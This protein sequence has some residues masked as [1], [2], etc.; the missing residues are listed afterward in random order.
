MK[1]KCSYKIGES[2]A[3]TNHTDVKVYFTK[4]LNRVLESTK[5]LLIKT[6][7][8]NHQ[9]MRPECSHFSHKMLTWQLVSFPDRVGL[10]TRLR[11]NVAMRMRIIFH[12][13]SKPRVLVHVDE[14]GYIRNHTCIP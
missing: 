9:R 3:I 11:G 6:E 4:Q 5:V 10:G 2:T 14:C 8:V 13:A 1:N 12:D 7:F